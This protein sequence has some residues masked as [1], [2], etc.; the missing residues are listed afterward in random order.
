[1][2]DCFKRCKLDNVT[3][4]YKD[5]SE[6]YAAAEENSKG[7]G[8]DLILIF[9]SFFLVSEYLAKFENV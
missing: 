4:G 3:F 9:G 5:F 8:S 1:M 6:T 2:Q 7:R